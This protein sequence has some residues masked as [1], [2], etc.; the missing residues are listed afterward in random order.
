MTAVS[1]PT[2]CPN[3][4]GSGW[5]WKCVCTPIWAGYATTCNDPG[6]HP[7]EDDNC[8]H[9]GTQHTEARVPI[10][11]L[12]E[13]AKWL[14][15]AYD[16]PPQTPECIAMLARVDAALTDDHDQPGDIGRTEMAE[17]DDE[18]FARVTKTGVKHD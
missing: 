10:S 3:C 7:C 1:K 17:I 13:A 2:T 15:A 11:L 12:Q 6:P 5:T 16:R 9:H 14:H 18:E 4:G 8:P